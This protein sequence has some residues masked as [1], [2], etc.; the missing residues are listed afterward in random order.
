MSEN[1]AEELLGIILNR[2]YK[3]VRQLGDGGMAYVFAAERLHIGDQVA[4]KLLHSKLVPDPIKKRRFQL[5]A[6]TTAAVKHPNVVS[7]FDYDETDR[8]EPYLVLELLNGP[9]L[10]KQIKNGR[11]LSAGRT[12]SI[13]K[14]V[15]GALSLAHQKGIL[16]RDLKPS[17]IVLH[18]LDDGTQVVKLIDFGIVKVLNEE[19]YGK[20]TQQGFVVGTPE[21]LSPERYSGRNVDARSDIY[22]LGVLVYRMLTGRVPFTGHSPTE[23]LQKHVKHPVPPLRL[24]NAG[25]AQEVE[26]VVLRA[27]SKR[28]QER[29]ETANQFAAELAQACI[30][31]GDT[32]DHY[33]S[34]NDF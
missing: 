7:V 10:A 17:N 13:I 26:E 33:S 12:L 24:L 19:D 20:L 3:L 30:S 34:S 8:G 18:Q 16:H 29:P 11:V 4:I 15:C 5:E 25:I 32:L 2:K 23:I 6:Y 27:L 31:S 9:T 14:P 1:R 22:S 28:P 21:Y